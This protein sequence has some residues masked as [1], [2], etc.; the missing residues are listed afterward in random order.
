MIIKNGKVY[1]SKFL[2]ENADIKLKEDKITG[3]GEFNDCCSDEA[4]D[5]RGCMVIPGFVDVH[6]H[7][8]YGSDFT[9]IDDCDVSTVSKFYA[10]RG[11]ASFLATTMTDKKELLFNVLK[12]LANINKEDLKGA[13]MAGIHLEGPF[14]SPKACGAQPVE[15]IQQPS[16]EAFK[17]YYDASKGKV[18]IVTLAPEVEGSASMVKY[19]RSLG[20]VCSAGHTKA[21]YQQAMDGIN[22]GIS[23]A[24]HTFNAMA[25]FH[26][27]EP[28]VIGAFFDAQDTTNEVIT[29][30]IHVHACIIRTIYKVKGVDHVVGMTDSMAATGLKNGSVCKLGKQTVYAKDGVAT[31]EDGTLAGSTLTMDL[32]LKNMVQK[33]GIPLEDAV[34]IL[35][36]N[37]A[38]LINAEGIGL[39]KVGYK[40]DVTILDS[41]FNVKYT[42]VDGK[43]VYKAE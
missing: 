29:D 26:H 6:T 5:A 4:I 30:L 28:G 33:I 38:K 14:I 41:D 43:V 13:K 24:T 22:A 21:T 1:N 8:A 12:T 10:S 36:Y 23:H 35:T 17:E 19:A 11:V 34:K 40:A 2:F 37:P 3:I 20:V 31:L 42:I 9:N 15:C 39:L 27:R 16:P 7:G 25:S 32:A 18:K